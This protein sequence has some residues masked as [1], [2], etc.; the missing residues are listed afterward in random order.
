MVVR[1]NGF[2]AADING[3]PAPGFSSAQA[4]AAAERI[5]AE[6]LPAA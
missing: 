6:T 1:Y 2:T 5:A 4:E 3:G